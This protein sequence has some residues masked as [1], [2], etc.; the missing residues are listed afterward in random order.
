MGIEINAQK[1]KLFEYVKCVNKIKIK[2]NCNKIN[3]NYQIY[4]Y[5]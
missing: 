2:C 5:F 4:V 1:D 3:C